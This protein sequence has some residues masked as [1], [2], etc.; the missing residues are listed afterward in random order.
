MF[1]ATLKTLRS[2]PFLIENLENL[3]KVVV[4]DNKNYLETKNVSMLFPCIH[5]TQISTP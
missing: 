5:E 3:E 4:Y 1:R 2:P